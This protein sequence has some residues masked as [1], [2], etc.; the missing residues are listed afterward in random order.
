MRFAINAKRWA[1]QLIKRSTFSAA[2]LLLAI[3]GLAMSAPFLLSGKA[4]AL[5][6]W[7]AGVSGACTVVDP[8]CLTI[9]AAIDAA[10]AG[11][12][13]NVTTGIY[14]ENLIINKAVDLE[15]SSATING[16]SGFAITLESGGV[17]ISGFT[18]TS[19]H[20]SGGEGIYNI[21]AQTPSHDI[22]GLTISHN[23]FSESSR[24]IA[25]E[26]SATG[27][28]TINDNQFDS[29][30]KDLAIADNS[31]GDLHIEGNTFNE[32]TSNDTGVQIGPDGNGVL[33]SF[34]F[35]SNHT[36]GNVNIGANVKGATISG[37]TFNYGSVTSGGLEFQAALHNS[38]VVSGNHFYGNSR[39][40]CLQLFGDQ[41]AGLVASNGVTV[42][43]NDFHDCGNSSSQYYNY[44]IQLSQDVDNIT[45]NGNNTIDNAYDG[46]NTRFFSGS[47]WTLNSGISISGNQITNSRHL[48]VNNTVSGTLN[49]SQN[50]FGSA[51]DP[52]SLV[53]SGVTVSP[54]CTLSDCSSYTAGS[55][56]LSLSASGGTATTPS[57]AAT[58]LSGSTSAGSVSVSIPSGTQVTST[59][60]SWDGVIVPP[61]VTTYSVPSG[62]TALAISVGSDDGSSLTFDQ[63]VKLVLPGQAG[64]LAGFVKNG[65]FTQIS[66]ACS[67]ST[68]SISDL[69][70]LGTV[71]ACYVA[72]DGSGNLVI[73]TNHFTTFVAY[74]AN[75]G[76]G[77]GTV[78][79][80]LS[81]NSYTVQSGDTFSTIADKF[82]LSL[83]QLEKLNPT[84]GHPAG[85]FDFILPGDVL[86]VG[87]AVVTSSAASSTSAA[88][89]TP[90]AA[91]AAPTTKKPKTTTAAATPAKSNTANYV[92]TAIIA[93]LLVAGIGF[94]NYLPIKKSGKK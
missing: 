41:F 91:G 75:A 87:S 64:K 19:T 70:A 10:S 76:S 53:S 33:H 13:I 69:N 44:A 1:K 17:T 42:S 11:E 83:T 68:P 23:V 20:N 86:N 43:G 28:V 14:N 25:L 62:T 82:G 66:T 39:Y 80:A 65:S 21:D 47:A 9:Q 92:W 34:E 24:A 3:N 32:P 50:W 77:G 61:T 2:A 67:S 74:S 37:N 35:E 55:Q 36:Y 90:V 73:W 46:I 16:G 93:A 8:N 79:T 81:H 54:W 22:S 40:A 72:D 85:N 58:S 56:N 31:F 6:T 26:S 15:G 52:S 45:I 63:P 88:N 18:I 60:T 7:S 51:G 48:A 29:Q 4:Y 27:T 57:G 78:S 89:S 12:I 84:A 71:G 5:T 59:N 94:Y 49:A 38:S 30:D